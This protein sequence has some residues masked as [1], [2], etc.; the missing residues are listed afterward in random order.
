V[1][2]ARWPLATP[3][4]SEDAVRVGLDLADCISVIARTAQ[5]TKGRG[6]GVQRTLPQ[7]AP[8]ADDARDIA[9]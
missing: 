3:A 5:R 9:G 8:A 4:G 7:D 2:L 6:R 1:P